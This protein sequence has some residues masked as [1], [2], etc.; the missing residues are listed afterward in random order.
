[1]HTS[2]GRIASSH[3]SRGLYAVLK[4]GNFIYLSLVVVAGWP[5]I[6]AYGLTAIVV[7]Y[8]LARGAAEIYESLL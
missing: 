7:A 5:I 3:I 6:Y 2:F 8:S 4:T 1:M